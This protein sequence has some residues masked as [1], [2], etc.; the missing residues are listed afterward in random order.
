MQQV[1]EGVARELAGREAVLERVAERRRLGEQ[2][3]DAAPQVARC[4]DA[5]QLAEAPAR[6]AV[7]G[8]RDDRGDLEA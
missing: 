5:E 3:P 2:R 7:V 8:D 4:R 6:A 1:A